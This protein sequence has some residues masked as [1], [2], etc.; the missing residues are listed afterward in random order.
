MPDNVSFSDNKNLAACTLRMEQVRNM[1]SQGRCR[2]TSAS[3]VADLLK[4]RNR[5]AHKGDF[6]RA[7]LV[8]GSKGMAGA[9]IL[10]ARAAL[11]SG[12]GLLT[13]HLPDCNNS[14]VQSSVPE[15][16][17]VSDSCDVCI[18]DVLPTERYT[19]VGVGPGLGR[20]V[21]T[22][23][24][25]E[26]LLR[27]SRSP[28][29]LDADALNILSSAPSLLDYIPNGS[30]ITPHMGEFARL[31]DGFSNFSEALEK[32]KMMSRKYA[33]CIVLKG[34]CTV[35]LSPSGECFVNT[36]GNVGM[37]TGGSG[38]VLTG[39]LLALLAQGYCAVDAAR[40]AVYVHGAAGDAAAAHTGVTA[41]V[42]GDIVEHL[43]DSWRVLESLC[44]DK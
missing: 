10:A 15:A 14:I 1:L 12:V 6:G 9:S 43:R 38:D 18:S 24:A 21:R 2:L 23:R 35:V 20:D 13:V 26:G 41:M 27:S 32:A 30:V 5:Y 3:D 4:P 39:V 44:D 31:A 28:M 16:M 8:A 40:I 11:R 29:V 22:V 17:T 33:L 19:A 34:A 7:L 42:A 36:T 25:I 37:A